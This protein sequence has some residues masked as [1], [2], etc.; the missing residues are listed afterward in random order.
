MT[1]FISNPAGRGP[2]GSGRPAPPRRFRERP[3]RVCPIRRRSHGRTRSRQVRRPNDVV[4]R[5][6]SGQASP[7]VPRS[8]AA[9]HRAKPGGSNGWPV[10]RESRKLARSPVEGTGPKSS[11][12]AS[13]PEATGSQTQA[14][15]GRESATNQRGPAH[16]R[17]SNIRRTEPPLG[18]AHSPGR[19]G[20]GRRTTGSS[21]DSRA[22]STAS[23]SGPIIVQGRQP[24]GARPSTTDSSR[25]KVSSGSPTRRKCRCSSA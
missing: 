10:G 4:A 13:Y 19:K 11:N 5:L 9:N 1:I 3:L 2:H 21:R 16:S 22:S 6:S 8:A 23:G 18:A 7:P 25:G 20:P 14:C 12:R 17:A 15:G 24:A